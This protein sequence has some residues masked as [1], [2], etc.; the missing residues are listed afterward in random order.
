M[1]DEVLRRLLDQSPLGMLALDADDG[2]VSANRAAAELLGCDVPALQGADFWELVPRET[3]EVHQTVARLV[4]GKSQPYVFL[5]HRRFEGRWVEYRLSAQAQGC[6][7][8]LED[9][10]VR[11]TAAASLR[12][13]GRRVAALFDANPNAMWVMDARSRQIVAA[14]AAAEV[15]YGY[16][17]GTL[18]GV[19][20]RQLYAD[21]GEAEHLA[22]LAEPELH[23]GRTTSVKLCRQKKL[24]GQLMLVELTGNTM[25]W[26]GARAAIVTVND[27][28][29]RGRVDERLRRRAELLGR[30]VERQAGE[31]E[32]AYRELETF[33]AAMSHD[34]QSPLHI[35]DGFAKTL[36]S[37]YAPVLDDQG[38][39][40]LQ[41]IQASAQR[42]SRMVDDLRLLSRI[43]RMALD[44]RAVDLVPVCVG[45]LEALR[46][47]EPA[48]RV[49]LEIDPALPVHGDASMLGMVMTCL[50]ENAWKFTSAKPQGWIKI[51]LGEPAGGVVRVFI[52]DNGAGF[53]P[54]YAHKLFVPFQ[55][56]HSSAEF[57]GTGLGLAIVQRMVQRHGGTVSAKS[58][59]GA[60]ATFHLV[61]PLKPG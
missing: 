54:A 25:E 2:V 29:R 22:M 23:G 40:Y 19:P 42:M 27:M 46:R 31:L 17:P 58:A 20:A 60:G 37:R 36:A 14:N 50:I 34:L 43:P 57:P 6:L 10:T 61:L 59:P 35:V 4:L 1:A 11:E 49:D 13:S 12:E 9:V 48:R 7:A 52:S 47:R 51:G 26:A 44:A 56:L 18:A 3:A 5:E 45:I 21:E 16:A 24:D 53:D 38:F 15:F 41:R 28:T 8:I 55:R 39:H 32:A 30:K 33:I